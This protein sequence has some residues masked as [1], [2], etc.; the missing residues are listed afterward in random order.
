MN[1]KYMIFGLLGLFAVAMVSAVVVNY[2]SD[3]AELDVKVDYATIVSFANIEAEDAGDYSP[4]PTLDVLS[5]WAN[6]LEMDTTQL[7]TIEAGVQII[8]N[9]DV[10]IEG[11]ILEVTVSDTNNDVTCNDITSLEFLDTATP[12]Q[13]AKGYQQLAGMGLCKSNENGSIYYNIPINSL[14]EETTYEYPVR[15]TFGAVDPTNY[16]F[17]AQMIINPAD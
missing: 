5:A 4:M 7:S 1:K 2:L 8:N 6:Y 17:V 16:K 10:R 3:T 13:L 15:V 11:K 9:A 12:I 14:L